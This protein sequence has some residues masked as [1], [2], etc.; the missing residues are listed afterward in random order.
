MH[1]MKS[2][3]L[4]R[5]LRTMTIAKFAEQFRLRVTHDECADP[6]ILGTLGNLYF[7]DGLCLMV[8][9]GAPANKSPWRAPRWTPLDGRHQPGQ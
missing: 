7:A 3:Q 1:Q 4:D 6:I 5:A 9:D 8:K 2:S